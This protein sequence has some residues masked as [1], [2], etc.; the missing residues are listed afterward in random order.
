VGLD[1]RADRA[2]GRC[3]DWFAGVGSHETRP[4]PEGFAGKRK[5]LRIQSRT[6]KFAVDGAG[7]DLGTE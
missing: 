5:P 1:P 6:V 4:L 3:R 7:V 2:V